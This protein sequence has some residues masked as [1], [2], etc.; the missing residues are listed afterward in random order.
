M[1]APITPRDRS[2]WQMTLADFRDAVEA[3]SMPG[4]GAAA[5]TSAGIGLALVLKG[6]RMTDDTPQEAERTAL[7]DEADRTLDA[8]AGYA[9]ADVRAF[10]DYLAARKQSQTGRGDAGAQDPALADA[11]ERI[12]RIPVDTAHRCLDGLRLA[13]RAIAHTKTPLQSDTQAGARM[14]HAGL[15]AV[16]LNVDANIANLDDGAERDRLARARAELQQAADRV[17]ADIRPAGGSV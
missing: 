13:A 2:L 12:N 14:L 3:R 10:R 16:L 7:V 11:V 6:L 17:L 5:A 4:C 15:C 1:H 9:D 8:L